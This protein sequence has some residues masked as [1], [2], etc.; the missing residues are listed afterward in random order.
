M[1]EKPNSKKVDRQ[2]KN[3]PDNIEQLIQYY[4]LENIWKHIGDIIDCI[5]GS[6]LPY[7][8]AY[9]GNIAIGQ[10]YD[11]NEGSRLQVNGS[12]NIPSSSVNNDAYRI[13]GNDVLRQNDG[14]NTI[15]V[16]NNNNMYFR[17][18]GTYSTTGQAV[19]GTDGILK[20]NGLTVLGGASD[21][22]CHIRNIVGIKGDGSAED[23]LYLQYG[24]NKPI[25]LGNTG[26]YNISADGSTYSGKASTA[27]N[28]DTATKLETA[29]NIALTGRITGNTN[30]DGSGNI[31]IATTERPYVHQAGGTSGT[32][33]YVKIATLNVTGG[34]LNA[35]L[36]FSISRRHDNTITRLSIQ[37][38]ND[39]SATSITLLH[40]YAFGSTIDAWIHLESTGTSN[41]VFALYI[42]KSEAYDNISIVDYYKPNYLANVAV[43][44]TNVHANELPTSNITQ[45]TWGYRVNRANNADASTYTT[46]IR[47]T[48][49]APASTTV[50]N[51]PFVDGNNADTNY[52]PRTNDGFRYQSKN[53]TTSDY[54]SSVLA[55]GNSIATGTAGNKRGV[56]RLFAKTSHYMDLI[57]T[58]TATTDVQ[59]ILPTTGGTLLNT[60][61]TSVTQTVTSGTELATLKINGTDTKL[62]CPQTSPKADQIKLSLT[63]PT[64]GTWYYPLWIAGLDNNGYYTSRSNNGLKYYTLEGTTSANG[65]T[66]LQLGNEIASGTAGNKYG[67]L[68]LY[69]T[70]TG[71]ATLQYRDTTTS[72]TL[73]LPAHNGNMIERNNLYSNTSG[74]TGNVTLSETSANFDA[75]EITY[76]DSTNSR[77]GY[78]KVYNPDGKGF[79]LQYAEFGSSTGAAVL[80]GRS[81][82]ISGTTI[83]ASS[84]YGYMGLADSAAT[85][86]NRFQIVRVDGIK[87]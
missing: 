2:E 47:V 13:N 79:N 73:T 54:G 12:I 76:K 48:P 30:F 39:S 25:V 55:I 74:T 84:N 38:S 41:R 64:S 53:G 65:R 16:G 58:E 8:S 40:F 26:S 69:H 32:A 3:M 86:T 78:I 20:V 27:G 67:Q 77:Y 72:C 35:P 61:T 9:N 49:T 17:P 85:H 7:M 59:Q 28:A 14:G 46:N 42:K 15:L 21:K 70:N 63:N 62:Y 31:S 34:Y 5:N 10:D 57:A 60:G 19:L 66:I 4:G 56:L 52:V 11:V 36:E 81:Y 37:F 44:F 18:T 82:S 29:R 87:G 24:A 50:Y 80:F 22:K 23:N 33:G 83:T 75:L 45:A 1:L 43:T 51:I 6:A 68:R 71:S